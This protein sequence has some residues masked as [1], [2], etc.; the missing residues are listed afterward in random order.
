LNSRV[1]FRLSITH[2]RFHKTPNSVS[3][4]PGTAQNPAVM[5]MVTVAPGPA[6]AT[7]ATAVFQSVWLAT[8]SAMAW[9]ANRLAVQM[10]VP[11]SQRDE[12]RVARRATDTDIAFPVIFLFL[13]PKQT[14]DPNHDSSVQ[15]QL[16]QKCSAST[17][18]V[19]RGSVSGRQ[20]VGAS[21]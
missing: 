7:A 18:P 17:I 5:L 19:K 8:L 16:R 4:K 13:Q 12:R 10:I 6:A 2:L 1:N 15:S 20:F 14:L 3:S 21:C 11:A 9:V